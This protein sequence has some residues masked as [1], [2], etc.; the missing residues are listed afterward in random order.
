MEQQLRSVETPRV[1]A[2]Y[3]AVWFLSLQACYATMLRFPQ[4]YEIGTGEFGT[5]HGRE[6]ELH[7][8]RLPV[9]LTPESS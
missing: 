6:H 9:Q 7:R 2:E 4:W 5:R 3:E 8:E 1:G